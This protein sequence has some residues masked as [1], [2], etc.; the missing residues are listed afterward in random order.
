[1]LKNI[2]NDDIF[3]N[4]KIQM[5]T[6]IKIISSNCNI[7]IIKKKKFYI[8]HFETINKSEKKSVRH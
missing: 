7:E 8:N 3:R 4:K 5:K 2:Q 1:M 6:K